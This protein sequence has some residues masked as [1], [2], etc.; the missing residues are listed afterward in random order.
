M[1]RIPAVVLVALGAAMVVY[2]IQ[3]AESFSSDLS[4]FF[5]GSPTDK[6]LWLILGGLAASAIGLAL[7]FRGKAGSN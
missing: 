2:G 3:A 6:T 4:R 7:L 5:T 1:N